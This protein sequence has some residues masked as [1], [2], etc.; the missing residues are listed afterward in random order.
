MSLDCHMCLWYGHQ[1]VRRVGSACPS[2]PGSRDEGLSE[3]QS[4]RAHSGRMLAVTWALW[5]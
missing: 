2:L 3:G 5:V 4:F 1:G